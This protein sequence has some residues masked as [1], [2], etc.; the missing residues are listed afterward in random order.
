MKKKKELIRIDCNTTD[1][2]MERPPRDQRP[3]CLQCDKTIVLRRSWWYDSDL[4]SSERP[5]MYYYDGMSYFCSRNCCMAYAH[6][7]AQEE[8]NIPKFNKV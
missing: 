4:P 5:A 1:L 8:L 3:K 2:L 7:K 6:K